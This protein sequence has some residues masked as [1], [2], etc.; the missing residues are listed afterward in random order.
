MLYCG[1]C[2]PLGDLGLSLTL[3]DE[4]T[5]CY[6]VVIFRH[7]Y[8]L[9]SVY[10]RPKS[11]HDGAGTMGHAHVGNVPPTFTNGW[12]RGGGTIDNV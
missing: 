4:Q 1:I 10:C 3:C 5:Y 12:A 9:A 7:E 8:I 11:K 2:L 6:V